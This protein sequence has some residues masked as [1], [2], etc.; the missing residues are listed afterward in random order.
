MNQAV[1]IVGPGSAWAAR[2]GAQ[3]PIIVRMLPF[4]HAALAL[5]L[6]SGLLACTPTLNWREV[7]A[8]PTSA[9][10]LL[11][12]KPDHA[13]RSVPLGGV[14]TELVVNGCKAGG[15]TFAV[16][17]ATVAAGRLPDDLLQG[18]QQATLSHM[19]AT[20]EVQRQPFHPAGA[21]PLAHAQ[22]VVAQ[23]QDAGG[24]AVY[25]QA[26]WTARA[27]DG[28]GTELVH[29]VMYSERPQPEVANAFFGGLTWR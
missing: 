22:R 18:W 26:V 20:G 28:G 1:S 19:K 2:A 4:R 29:A 9:H 14:P 15:A 8:A 25:T 6:L 12:C 21:L 23:G 11:P 13:E 17:A 3:P 27:A 24:R 10:A 7:A 5:L 16:M